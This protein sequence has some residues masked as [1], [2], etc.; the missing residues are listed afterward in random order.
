MF[1]FLFL[2]TD[3]YLSVGLKQP[4]SPSPPPPSGLPSYN[5]S[6]AILPVFTMT[7]DQQERQISMIL[8]EAVTGIKKNS[9]KP[10]PHQPPPL[11]RKEIGEIKRHNVNIRSQVYKAIRRPGKGI[12]R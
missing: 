6:Q 8:H 2:F 3:S 4:R 11:T 12:F 5:I 10:V 7:D 9:H 1:L